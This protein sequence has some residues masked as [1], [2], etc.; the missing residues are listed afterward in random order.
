[1]VA[2]ET[3]SESGRV[4]LVTGAASGIGLAIV[5]RLSRDGYRVVIGDINEA[6]GREQAERLRAGGA[7]VRFRSLDVTDE[8]SVESVV[9]GVAREFGSLGVLVNNAGV[10]THAPIEDLALEDWRRVLAVDLDGVFLGLRAAGRVMLPQGAGVIVNIASIAWDRGAA[11]RA[12][13]VVSKAG[14]VG[15][16]RVAA[17]EWA[18]S[19]IRVNAVAP[20]YIET[21]LLRNAFERGAI[22][23]AD[24]LAR[25]PAGR[26]ARIEEIAEVVA[27]LASPAAAYIT[28]Q[29]LVVDGGFLADFGVGL[30]RT[31]RGS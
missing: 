28:G 3:Q 16:T 19:G 17:V 13:Y 6:G 4:A 24:V 27:F 20:G 25:I 31:T 14:V 18:G 26:V 11:G 9:T 2:A 10:T 5:E 29:V 30:R 12:P 23:E 21:P 15:L 22:D 8:A 7:D 1:M